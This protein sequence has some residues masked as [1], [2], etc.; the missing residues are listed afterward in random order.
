MLNGLLTAVIVVGGISGLLA[1][2]M[3]IADNTIGN[4]GD[5]TVT[6]NNKKEYTVR[7]GS[8]LLGALMEQEIFIPSACGGRGSCGFCK[9]RVAEGAGEL[10]PTELPH[11]TQEEIA[12][13]IRLSCQ[14]KVKK[15]IKIEIP[16]E[17]FS[18]KQFSAVVASIRDLTYDIKEVT[19][20]LEEPAAI[21]FKAGQYVQ[22]L[23]PEYEKCDEPVYRAYSVS[24]APSL[25]DT[26][27]LEIRRV[28]NG[29]CTTYVHDY[30][31]EGDRVTFNGPYGEFYLRDSDNDIIFLAGGSGNAPIKSILSDM[32]EK[33]IGRKALYLFGARSEKDLFLTEEMKGF[34]KKLKD[35]RYL[36]ALSEPEEGSGWDGETGLI[37]EVLDRNLA[38]GSK[39][40]AY[41]CGSPGMIGACVE[42]LK[43][44]GVGED[45]IFY[46]K[47]A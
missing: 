36:P 13:N 5:V 23:T 32:A 47:F 6:V 16:E 2:L 28:P 29:I 4:Y 31:K 39:T 8:T 45:R 33:G 43:K 38:D 20:R 19:F 17:L 42:I 35:F 30:L 27:E 12:D 7:G 40:E 9:V 15:D 41:L 3:V 1:V 34:E 37:T 46:D 26:V 18:V 22:I 21:D 25:K 14:I 44:K 24:S 10:L 11:L